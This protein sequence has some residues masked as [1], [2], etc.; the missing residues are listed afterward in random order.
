MSDGN[1]S[2]I[3]SVLAAMLLSSFSSPTSPTFPFDPSR[4]AIRRREWPVGIS[5]LTNGV[6]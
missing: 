1:D 4:L 2:L 3:V 6:S 5:V